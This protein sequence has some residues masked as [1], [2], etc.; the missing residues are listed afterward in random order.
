VSVVVSASL[1]AVAGLGCLA[2][3]RRITKRP[4]RVWTVL[5]SAVLVLSLSGPLGQAVGAGATVILVAVHLAVA[6]VLI[7]LGRR[8]A[9][10]PAR[11]R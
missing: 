10:A 5:A 2:V 11:T 1:T 4:A 7:P 6:A 3:L 9:S 8:L